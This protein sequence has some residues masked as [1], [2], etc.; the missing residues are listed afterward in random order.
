[1]FESCTALNVT[2]DS[3]KTKFF[4]CP[5]EAE[6]GLSGVYLMFRYKLPNPVEGEVFYYN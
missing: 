6:E 1:M 5:K 3:G 4:T 2:K